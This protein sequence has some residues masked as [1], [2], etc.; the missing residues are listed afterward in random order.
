VRGLTISVDYYRIKIRGQIDSLSITQI[1]QNCFS[2]DSTAAE[3][4]LIDQPD[5][6]RLPISVRTIPIDTA[7][8]DTGGID[9]DVSLRTRLGAGDL[10]VQLYATYL[11]RYRTEQSNGA[12]VRDFAGFGQTAN[13]PVGR[14]RVRG[15]LN[16][17][18]ATGGFGIALSQQFLGGLKIGSQEPNQNHAEKTIGP[19]TY[20]DVSLRQRIRGY[21]CN[22]EMFL[23]INNLFDRAPPLV[24]GTIPGLNFPTIISVYDIVGRAFT[25]GVRVRF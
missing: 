23:T 1:A 18:Y 16:A 22:A 8:L 20:T 25:A 15:E 2:S 4:D 14:P 19:V 9:I 24:P 11:D 6:T 3:C 5:P 7:F 12:P 17:D 10:T 13:Q 21:R